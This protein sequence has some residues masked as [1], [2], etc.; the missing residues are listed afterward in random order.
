MQFPFGSRMDFGDY[1]GGSR[2][3]SQC[4]CNT[5][6]AMGNGTCN[7]KAFKKVLLNLLK[8]H[9][10]PPFTFYTRLSQ[11]LLSGDSRLEVLCLECIVS[12]PKP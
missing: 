2:L 12:G 9:I 1:C 5:T 11:Y 3:V 6:Q 10:A 7:R 4:H 8:H